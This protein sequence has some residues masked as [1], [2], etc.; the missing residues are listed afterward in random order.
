MAGIQI[1]I[2]GDLVA[3]AANVLTP[4]QLR[5]ALFQVIKRTTDKGVG[6]AQKEVQK[7]LNI[8]TKYVKRA[9]S[10]RL[11]IRDPA[12]PVGVIR[13]TRRRL[14]LIAY[15]LSITKRG[16]VRAKVW[17][18]RSPLHFPHGFRATVN[19]QNAETDEQLHD[20]VFIRT[21]HASGNPKAGKVTPKGFA[22]R[23]AIKQL[24]GPSVESAVEIPRIS[25]AV[26]EGLKGEADKQ[27]QSQINRFTK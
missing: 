6:I 4:D 24:R 2:R 23:L 9:V 19:Q 15:K 7:H 22:G 25:E 21:R 10:K 12:P 27:M 5:R 1:D 14:P 3:S 26:Y 8:S 11:E 13:F 20:G 17:S 18:D 16:G